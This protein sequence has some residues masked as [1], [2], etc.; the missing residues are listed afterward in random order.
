MIATHGTS[1]TSAHY[2]RMGQ[3]ECEKIHAGVAWRSWQ[4]VGVD[5]HDDNARADPGRRRRRGGWRADRASPR[6]WW[7]SAL[8]TAPK[9]ITLYDRNGK[10][11]MR[12]GSY[13]TYYGG[14]SDCLNILDHRT[15]AAAEAAAEGL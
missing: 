12:A 1:M 10:V 5:V 3:P 6:T 13:N 2:A 7:R 8:S 4:R 15:G 9:F 14:G 11:A